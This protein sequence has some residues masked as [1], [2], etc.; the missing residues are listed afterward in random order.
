M[1]LL[2][3]M[4]TILCIY[5]YRRGNRCSYT[6]LLN[7]A[8]FNKDV[9]RYMRRKNDMVILIDIDKFKQINDTHGHAYG[10]TVIANLANIISARVRLSDRAYRIGGDEFAIITS[11]A[12]VGDRIKEGLVGVTISVGCGKTYEEAD[13]DMYTN[14][15]LRNCYNK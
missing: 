7:K 13:S 11:D 3:I 2:N 14:K 8:Q 10:D 1:I 12:S 6:G 5:L 9:K 4:L 15:S